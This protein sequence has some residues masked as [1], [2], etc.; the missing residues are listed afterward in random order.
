[1]FLLKAVCHIHSLSA[2]QGTSLIKD[3]PFTAEMTRSI[4][5]LKEKPYRPR[6]ADYRIGVFLPDANN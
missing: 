4:M 1:M 6:M 5:L 3:R 2:P